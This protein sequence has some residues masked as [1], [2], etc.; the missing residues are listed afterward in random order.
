MTEWH[1]ADIIC[2]YCGTK[3]NGSTP[4]G[5]DPRSRNAKPRAGSVSMCIQCG[6][7]SVYA[8]D[9]VGLRLRPPTE[10]EV[11]AMEAEPVIQ[12]MHEAYEE[13]VAKV[14]DGEAS[15]REMRRR[16]GR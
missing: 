3:H 6:G 15:V 4:V 5:T 14:R 10:E 16:L 11:E 13:T 2:P 12:K 1:R 8:D 9:F 7:F